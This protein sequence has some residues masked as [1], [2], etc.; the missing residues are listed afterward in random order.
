MQSVSL[1]LVAV[2]CLAFCLFCNCVQLCA[3]VCKCV[4]DAHNPATTSECWAAH[5]FL[6]SR[7]ATI[8][9]H[10][11]THTTQPTPHK[12]RCTGVA[13]VAASLC[14]AG[15]T[16]SY[17]FSQTIFSKRQGVTHPAN[18][19][20]IA[21]AELLLFMLPISVVEYMPNFFY[22]SLL[23]VF[24]IDISRDWLVH[25]CVEVLCVCRD[26]SKCYRHHRQ[27]SSHR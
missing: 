11:T 19:W 8:V 16:G 18:G 5:P 4:D 13:N 25:R 12:P 6:S 2:C 26:V 27:T 24:G 10:L 20:V 17:I 15:F 21:G 22:G 1:R 14:G 7:V 9:P 23:M 3:S